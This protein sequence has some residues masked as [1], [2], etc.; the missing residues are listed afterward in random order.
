MNLESFHCERLRAPLKPSKTTDTSLECVFDKNAHFLQ[1]FS[2]HTFAPVINMTKITNFPLFLLHFVKQILVPPVEGQLPHKYV[3][4]KISL[5]CQ[6]NLAILVDAKCGYGLS[7]HRMVD[8]WR[9]DQMLEHNF[10]VLGPP[11]NFD[12]LTVRLEVQSLSDRDQVWSLI[13]RIRYPRC[14]NSIL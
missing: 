3:F 13:F 8:C 14:F 5:F 1:E 10:A 7:H 9:W 4:V 2:D 11:V 12:Q 6:G